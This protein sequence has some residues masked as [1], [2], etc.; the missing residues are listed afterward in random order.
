V[1]D[2]VEYLRA[3]KLW[4]MDDPLFPATRVAVGA[5][6]HFEVAGLDRK[7]WGSAAPVRAIFKQAFEGAG[8]PAYPP[9]ASVRPWGNSA[10]SYAAT[11]RSSSRGAKTLGMNR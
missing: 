4:G 2:W 11:R 1:A 10:S 8:L 7:H 6:G 5:S 9:I 3:K